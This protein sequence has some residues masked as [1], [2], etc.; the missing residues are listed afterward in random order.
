MKT[1]FFILSAVLL[2]GCHRREARPDIFEF[3]KQVSL[4]EVNR[5]CQWEIETMITLSGDPSLYT[6]MSK[7]ERD[8][9]SEKLRARGIIAADANVFSERPV[10]LGG[11]AVDFTNIDS[12]YKSDWI[13]GDNLPFELSTGWIKLAEKLPWKKI[14]L[15]RGDVKRKGGEAGKWELIL[16]YE[17]VLNCTSSKSNS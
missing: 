14:V 11:L 12:F 9:L 10:R 6:K 1:L 17:S 3:P 5:C 15:L 16:D 8:V 4:S 13:T 2:I 7:N